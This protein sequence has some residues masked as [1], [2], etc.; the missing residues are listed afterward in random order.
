MGFQQ[1]QEPLAN[2]GRQVSNLSSI[3]GD[4]SPGGPISQS[5]A[6]IADEVAA[7][8]QVGG[9]ESAKGKKLPSPDAGAGA[10][11]SVGSAL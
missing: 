9:V 11:S 10:A 7:W 5:M 1:A 4:S 6:E 3:M 8:M 2:I